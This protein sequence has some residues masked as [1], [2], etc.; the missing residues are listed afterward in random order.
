MNN[1]NLI[2]FSMRFF[3][4]IHS[5]QIGQLV[6]L[7]CQAQNL[8]CKDFFFGLIDKN[9]GLKHNFFGL[10]MKPKILSR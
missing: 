10:K 4:I 1:K 3:L 7:L 5:V 8:L 2:V 9:F 6:V